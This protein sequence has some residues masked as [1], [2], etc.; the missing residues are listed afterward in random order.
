MW[1]DETMWNVAVFNLRPKTQFQRSALF[2]HILIKID[3][4]GAL[5]EIPAQD[6][7]DDLTWSQEGFQ[8]NWGVESV[9]CFL[10]DFFMV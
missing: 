5:S 2:K 7:L 6:D 4:K 3:S 10:Y 9:S 8:C 1:N